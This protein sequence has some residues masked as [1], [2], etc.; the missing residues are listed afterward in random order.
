MSQEKLPTL[1]YTIAQDG[2]EVVDLDIYVL[3]ERRSALV[4]VGHE[5]HESPLVTKP[6][7]LKRN[8]R[9]VSGFEVGIQ[10]D[11]PFEQALTVPLFYMANYSTFGLPIPDL[12]PI[13]SEKM[14]RPDRTVSHI[15]ESSILQRAINTVTI[16]RASLLCQQQARYK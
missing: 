12:H 10:V 6:C 2:Y 13:I 15:P 9:M 7:L 11:V 5:Q 1:R 8:E 14:I 16:L 3:P 4:R